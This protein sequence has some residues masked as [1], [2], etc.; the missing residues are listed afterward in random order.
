MRPGTFRL[1]G[2]SSE[3]FGVFVSET[4]QRVPPNARWA[5]G[6]PTNKNGAVFRNL[7]V[8]ENTTLAINAWFITKQANLD[9]I[10]DW[11]LTDNYVDFTPW[12]DDKYT[13]KVLINQDVTTGFMDK[14]TD[15]T[16]LKFS[17]TVYPFKYLNETMA[18]HPII[19]NSAFINPTKFKALPY[20]EVTPQGTGD[21]TLT[22]NGT[23]FTFKNPGAKFTIDSSIPRTSIPDKMVGLDFPVI[24]PGQNNISYTNVAKLLMAEKYTR[25]AG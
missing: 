2:V 11:L 19:N 20:L 6:N 18:T 8:Y 17:L 16:T 23:L 7:G 15:V 14:A 3:T 21:V 10:Y 13:Y 22:L 5:S 12:Y 1:N 24:K 25:R 9:D 4:P